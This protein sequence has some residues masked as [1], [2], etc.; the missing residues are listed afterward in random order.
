VA[1]TT[2]IA[3]DAPVYAFK[4]RMLAAEHVFR[5][6]PD[7]LEWN[8]GGRT[9]RI[10]YPM[11]A[12]IRV[13]FRFTNFMGHRYTAEI[14]PR[15]GGRMDISSVSSRGMLDNA[16][17]GVAYRAFIAELH[18]RVASARGECRFEAGMAVWRFWP[19][20]TITLAMAAA[21]VY[22][23]VRGILG[24]QIVTSLIVLAAGSLFVWQMGKMVLANK[25]R[26]YRPETI[27]EDLLPKI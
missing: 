10:A 22:V 19:S 11:I 15:S 5:L 16:N 3:D 25:P 7:S 27:P 6:G 20:V 18:R 17:Q 8:V 2:E 13:G 26:S 4:P 24:D 21:L 9:G 14:F 12:R 23:L 1:D